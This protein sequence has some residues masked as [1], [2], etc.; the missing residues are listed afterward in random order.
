MP[1]TCLLLLLLQCNVLDH[2]EHQW[3]TFFQESAEKILGKSAQEMG[4]LQQQV[5]LSS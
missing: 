1:W 3:V 5:T 2:T 4:D